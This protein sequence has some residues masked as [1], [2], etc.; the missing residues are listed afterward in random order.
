[1]FY[2]LTLAKF[3][4]VTENPAPKLTTSLNHKV[5]FLDNQGIWSCTI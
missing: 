3:Q 5:L 2:F 4:N 1:M